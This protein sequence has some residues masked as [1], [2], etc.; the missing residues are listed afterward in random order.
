MQ[1]SCVEGIA[2]HRGPESC[3]G[4]RKGA[5][6]ALTGAMY[7]L[8][9]G[10]RMRSRFFVQ[11]P[12]QRLTHAP[13]GTVSGGTMIRHAPYIVAP[14]RVFSFCADHCFCCSRYRDITGTRH[15]AHNPPDRE[16]NRAHLRGMIPNPLSSHKPHFISLQSVKPVRYRSGRSG[17][18][19]GQPSGGW[20][21]SSRRFCACGH[22][23][24]LPTSADSR[25][26]AGVNSCGILPC[27]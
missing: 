14:F 26:S 24:P 1:E 22:S 21:A 12:A 23:L 27:E 3:G 10:S 13:S 25:Q 15:G 8:G 6:E 18:L 16:L 19:E 11:R 9:G 5:A 4:I 2:N 20:S 7:G 17:L